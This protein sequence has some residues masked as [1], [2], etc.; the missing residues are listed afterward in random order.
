[1]NTRGALIFILSFQCD[2]QSNRYRCWE[3][4][5]EDKQQLREKQQRSAW[6]EGKAS[7]P[8]GKPMGS[9]AVARAGCPAMHTQLL[10]ALQE[11]NM[12]VSRA[13]SHLKDVFT[14]FDL[15]NCCFF[16]FLHLPTIC[17]VQGTHPSSRVPFGTQ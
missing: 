17:P 10:E 5:R 11:A 6:W 16:F 4:G 2:S 3:P 14:E 8:A 7:I 1:M 12:A 9:V 13:P 15:W